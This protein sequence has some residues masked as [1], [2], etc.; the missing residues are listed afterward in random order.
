MAERDFRENRSFAEAP[1]T[2]LLVSL[3]ERC[4]LRCVHCITDAPRRT[5]EGTARAMTEEVLDAL[6]P[7]LNEIEYVGLTHAGEPTAAPLLERFLDRLRLGKQRP[8]T[9]HVVTNGKQLDVA[10]FS[11]LAKLGVRSFCFSMDGLS[12][13][14]HDAIRIGGSFAALDQTLRELAQVRRQHFSHVRLGVSFTL[15]ALN[16]RE[17][18]RLPEYARA[19]GLDYV[20]LEE[21]VPLGGLVAPEDLADTVKLTIASGRLARIPVLDH[22]IDPPFECQLDSEDART[23]SELD[24][25][26][27]H[28][29]I[30]AC[31]LPFEQLCIEPNGDVRPVDFHQPIAG[32]VLDSSLLE[33]WNSPR[34]ILERNR[35]RLTRPCRTAQPTCPP[36]PE[37]AE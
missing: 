17:A 37:A 35:R 16:V 11:R 8:A 18:P 3:T 12:E 19:V 32:N 21:L 36:D 23:R 10:R 30:N 22:T 33:I 26:A 7:G 25:F 4:N 29:A 31:R 24:D 2:R 20:K 13:A 1:P 6:T 28:V 15:T 34:L 5:Q 9:V 14:S 27:N